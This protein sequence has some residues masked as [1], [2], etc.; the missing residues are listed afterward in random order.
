MEHPS[1]D[2]SFGIAEWM[3][4]AELTSGG[5]TS[6]TATKIDD[7]AFTATAFAFAAA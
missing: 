4:E 6:S 3:A 5:R 2:T 1:F 7:L